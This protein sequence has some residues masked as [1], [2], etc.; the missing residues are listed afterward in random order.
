MKNLPNLKGLSDSIKESR[1]FLNHD[2]FNYLQTVTCLNAE[3]WE[4]INKTIRYIEGEKHSLPKE[5][6][7]KCHSLIYDTFQIESNKFID[8]TRE[9]LEIRMRKEPETA[10]LKRL[11]DQFTNWKKL[12][13]AK[14]NEIIN[15]IDEILN[16]SD[17]NFATNDIDNKYLKRKNKILFLSANPRGSTLRLDEEVR[18]VE[19][20]VARVSMNRDQFEIKKITATRI[21]DLQQ[22][23]LDN[24][25]RF[26]HFS[27]HGEESGIY[28][29]DTNGD[30]QLVRTAALANFFSLYSDKIECV[31]LNS[32]YSENQA[33]AIVE[34]IPFVI[35]MNKAV[36][37]NLAI[38]F[39]ISFYQAIAA[40]KD[41]EFSFD[42]A[43][44][45]VELFDLHGS[46][47]P[48]IHIK[49]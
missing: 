40:G 27:G 34:S 38:Q 22:E 31:F 30:Y 42:F 45:S 48:I 2:F 29:N 7:E 21:I 41:V 28:L 32:C 19:Y 25:P 18:D 16:I 44:N 46:D 43:K 39:S 36:P 35:G 5:L 49:K 3:E 33:M 12:Y 24:T 6:Y 37:D 11:N 20:Q 15:E 47:I 14:S 8:I 13:T 23:L 10:V 1:D 4:W 26:L 9:L 17:A